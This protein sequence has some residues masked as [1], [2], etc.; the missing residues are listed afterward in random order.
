MDDVTT[1]VS[2][3]GAG[4]CLG[5]ITGLTPGL[6]VNTLLPFIV[7]LPVSGSMSAVLI[8]SLAVTHTF[9][10]FIP[11]TLFG[12]PD[13]D[14][15]LSILP[16][17]RLLLQG[18][19]YEAIKLTVV[20]SL[21]SLML[22]C[23]LAPLMIVLIPPL[24]A[25][26]SPYL[27]Y[28]L[29][30]FVAIMIGSEKSLLRISASGAVFIISGLYGYIALNSPWIGNDLVLFPMF[31][32]LFGIS[33]LLMS[34][35]CSTRLPLQ[36]FDTRIHLSRLQ[37][38]LNVVKGAGAGMLVS[39]FPG[40]GPA[41]ATAVI[42]MKSSPRTFL[43][44]VS[45]VNTAN[46]VYALIGM[47]TIGKARS[48]AVAVIQGLTEV[49]NAMLVQLLSC[50]LLAAGV[51]SVAALMV[52]QQMLKLISA[53]DYTAVTAGTCCI[54]VVLV[55]AMTGVKGIALMA[56]GC[57]I[58]LLPPLLGIRRSHC[59]GVLLFPILLHYLGVNL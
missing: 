39:L 27:A 51:A 21:G 46:A 42:S 43:V 15:A 44:A 33:T 30:G 58:G 24:H 57:S 37:I 10:D 7:L 53:V 9:L 1:L 28:I 11:S 17:H 48:G 54:L 20:G 38:M 50:G 45:G 4:I 12:V 3:C 52:A 26:I 41:H 2:M 16:A 59:M 19:G 18:R 47:Y 25:T 8:F 36:S 49:N 22:S 6:H 31:C 29:L 40:I 56:V 55:C 32:G 5:V 23:S 34:A 14:T 35:T 13:E